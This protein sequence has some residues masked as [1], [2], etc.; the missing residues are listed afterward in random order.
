MKSKF[1]GYK[2]PPI[3]CSIDYGNPLSEGIVGCWIFNEGKGSIVKNLAT[4]KNSNIINPSSDTWSNYN[5][6]CL[7]FNGSNRYIDTYETTAGQPLKPISPPMTIIVRHYPN[8]SVSR[9]EL[10]SCEESTPNGYEMMWQNTGIGY[11]I[12]FGIFGGSYQTVSYTSSE[13]ADIAPG[14]WI[15]QCGQWDNTT[16]LNPMKIYDNSMNV[17]NG[18][19]DGRISYGSSSV[20]IGRSGNASVNYYS[21]FIAHVFVWRRLLNFKQIKSIYD[22]PYQFLTFVDKNKFYTSQSTIDTGVSNDINSYIFTG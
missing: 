22:N 20:K 14:K 12:E 16:A 9:R 8:S 19:V 3:G 5:E 17:K 11:K 10:I 4:N 1:L 15:N 18:G 7:K 21:D 6:L 2:K 13:G